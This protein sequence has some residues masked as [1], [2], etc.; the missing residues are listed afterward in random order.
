MLRKLAGWFRDEWHANDLPEP[1]WRAHTIT[2]LM[3]QVVALWITVFALTLRLVIEMR[4]PPKPPQQQ[5]SLQPTT[6]NDPS[7]V[8]SEQA[9]HG[10]RR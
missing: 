10:I 9:R 3:V 8:F 7:V 6:P 2:L 5:R 1:Q 4:K